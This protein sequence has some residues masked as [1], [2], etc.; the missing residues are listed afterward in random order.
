MQR[1]KDEARYRAAMRLEQ[2]AEERGKI[3][4]LLRH[5]RE[6]ARRRS[7]SPAEARREQEEGILSMVRRTESDINAIVDR[8]QSVMQERRLSRTGGTSTYTSHQS[9]RQDQFAMKENIPANVMHTQHSS[10][11]YKNSVPLRFMPNKLPTVYGGNTIEESSPQSESSL[12]DGS[13]RGTYDHL[14]IEK[15]RQVKQE[16]EEYKQ[17]FGQMG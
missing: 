16:F 2:L 17:S 9:E 11:R 1:E 8:G 10:E 4:S 12:S 14:L 7:P 15:H 5:E 13:V 6:E 3:E